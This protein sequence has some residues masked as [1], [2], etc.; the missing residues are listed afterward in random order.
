MDVA[1]FFERVS[2][3]EDFAENCDC[4]VARWCLKI[5]EVG[6]GSEVVD[7]CGVRSGLGLTEIGGIAF[8]VELHATGVVADSGVRVAGGVV[9][10]LGGCA[11]SMFGRLVLLGGNGSQ[12][13]DHG[14]IDRTSVV[15]EDANGFKVSPT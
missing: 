1:E 14:Q 7:A 15:E 8:N 2:D 4:A 6:L 13:R 3:A 10:E 5:F 9:E 12:G 11:E